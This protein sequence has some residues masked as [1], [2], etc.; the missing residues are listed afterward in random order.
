MNL[1]EELKTISGRKKRFLLLRIIDV[2]TQAARQFCGITKGTYNSWLQNSAFVELYRRRS[3][4]AAEY[5]QEALQ[6][7]RRDNQLQAVFL[8]EKIIKR[9]KEEIESGV[10]E[11]IKT[12]LA[13]EVYSKL[14]SDLDYSPKSVSLTWEQRIA[15]LHIQ[16]VPRVE[17]GQSIDGEVIIPETASSEETEQ[18]E[19]KFLTESEQKSPQAQKKVKG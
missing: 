3:E 8:E 14:I 13:R 12:N 11:L 10:Y 5:K 1:R 16:D 4:F 6:L 15:Q 9:M 17:G 18:A 2:E 7:L 19:G